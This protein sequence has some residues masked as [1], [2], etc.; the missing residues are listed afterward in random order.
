MEFFHNK[1]SIQKPKTIVLDF[2][3]DKLSEGMAYLTT[4][5]AM[6]MSYDSKNSSMSLLLQIGIT[7]IN[8]PVCV[9]L[10]P[11]TCFPLIIFLYITGFQPSLYKTLDFVFCNILSLSFHWQPI[12]PYPVFLLL[13]LI[14]QYPPVL[15]LIVNQAR[16]DPLT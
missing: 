10:K 14:D 8:S 9:S 15:F 6:D 5:S 13:L 3:D 1:A 7:S 2:C 16:I 11:A 12:P 4:I